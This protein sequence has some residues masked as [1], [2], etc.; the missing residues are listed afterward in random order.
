[1]TEPNRTLTDDDVEAIV[2]SL[3]AQLVSDFYGEVGRGVWHW[4]KKAFFGLVLILAV[5]GMA[6]EAG[7]ALPQQVKP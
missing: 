4:V 3:K 6:R 1:M 7:I 2:T 5:Y